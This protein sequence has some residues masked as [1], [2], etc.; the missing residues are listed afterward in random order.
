[1]EPAIW[2]PRSATRVNKN[3]VGEGDPQGITPTIAVAAGSFNRSLSLGNGTVTSASGGGLVPSLQNLGNNTA[4]SIG[5]GNTNIVAGNNNVGDL[6]SN[7]TALVQ[8]ADLSAATVIGNNGFANVIGPGKFNLASAFGNGQA[9]AGP[10]DFKVAVAL[11][12]Q[13]K[14]DP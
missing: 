9:Q 2:P 13:I 10:G 8:G 4:F 1:M 3:F 7:S 14:R 12:G 5:N 11:P 6:G